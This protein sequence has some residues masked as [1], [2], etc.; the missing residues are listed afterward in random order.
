MDKLVIVG[1]GASGVQFALSVLKKGYEVVML[2]VGYEN[3]EK[4][5]P[6]DTFDDLKA[7]LKDPVSYFLGHNYES[8]IG[9]DNKSEYYGIPPSKTYVFQKPSGFSFQTKGFSPLFSFARGGLAEAWTGGVYPFNDDELHE[10][11]FGYND[12]EPYYSEVAGRI[13][14]A[15]VKDDLAQFYPF[16]ENIMGPLVL[17]QHSHLLLGTYE[18]QKDCLNNKLGCYIGRSRISTLNCDRDGRKAC[19]YTGRCLWGCPAQALYV[20][21]ITLNECRKFSNFKYVPNTFVTHFRFDARHRI[22]TVVGRSPNNE[23]LCEFPAD[24]LILAAGTLCSSR[25]FMD[26]IYKETGETIKLRGLMDNRQILVPFVNLKMVGKDYKP[27]TYQYHQ[28]VLC[29]KGSRPDESIH[30]QIT[31]LKTSLI[32]PIIQNMPLDLKTS[33]F[34]F[35]NMHA[36][37]GVV[38]INLHDRRREENFLTLEVDQKSSQSRLAIQYTPAPNE[39]AYLKR[40]IKE[41]KRALWKLGCIA[42]SGMIHIRPMGASVHYSGTIPMSIT[43]MAY[44]A[45]EDC[46]SHDFHN[47]YFVDGTTFPFL[48]AKNLTFTLMANAARVADRAF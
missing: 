15:G 45:S 30:G 24:R 11:P 31:T 26:S 10:F 3:P 39:T 47:L 13:G 29:I 48:P 35:R 46:R 16:H 27:E 38:N 12:I 14:I 36:A 21:S 5:N 8:F 17:D 4:V 1:S 34:M 7:N 18:K 28:I 43:K 19:S 23:N 42:P 6:D 22:T 32:H 37:L 25:I 41:V 33:I 20:P 9:P 2:D 44:T 40:S